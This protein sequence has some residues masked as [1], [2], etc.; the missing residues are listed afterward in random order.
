MPERPWRNDAVTTACPVCA[1]PF[2]PVG[3]QQVCSAAC[4]QALWRRRHPTP[5]PPLPTRSARPATVYE[6][7]GCDTRSI[8][9]QRCDDCGRF[10][11]RVGPGGPCPHCD[12]PVA[13]ADLLQTP[14]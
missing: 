12:E 4:R 11:R 5:L 13:L 14:T 8:G 9:R 1:A 10:G 3:R 7:P 6:C 2:R